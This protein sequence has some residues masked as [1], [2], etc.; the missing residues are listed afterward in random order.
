[1]TEKMG[2]VPVL[3]VPLFDQPSLRV[4]LQMPVGSS[5]AEYIAAALPAANEETLAHLRVTLVSDRGAAVIERA[6]WSRVYPHEGV[7]VVLRVIP[8]KNALRSILQ[9]VV[10]IAA[11]AIG[12]IF[13][14]PLAGALGISTGLASAVIGLGVT[15]LGGML[16]N[17]LIPPPR[18]KT[19]SDADRGSPVYAISG[20]RNEYRPGGVI[21]FP[22]GSHRYAPPYACP[23]YSEVVGDSHYIRAVFIGGYGP[24]LWDDLRIGETS[25]D[26]FQSVTK[27]IRNGWSNDNTLTFYPRQVFEENINAELTRPLPRSAGGDVISGASIETPVKRATGLDAWQISIIFSF[28]GGLVQYN[29]DGVAQTVQV[30]FRVRY[31]IAGTE[32]WTTHASFG[33]ISKKAE[34]FFRQYTF[35][36]PARGRYEIEITRLTDEHVSPKIQSRSMFAVLQTIRPE[37]PLNFDKKLALVAVRALATHQLQGSLD[38]FNAIVRCYCQDFDV[39]TGTWIQRPTSNPA[40]LYKYVLT[41]AANPRAVDTDELDWANLIEWHNFCRIKGLKYDRVIDF[42]ITLDELLREIAAAGRARPRHDGIRYGVVIDRPQEL[43][44]DHINPRNSYNFRASR[45]YSRKPHGFRVPFVDA[46][47]DYQPSERIVRWPGYNGDITLTERLEMPG[48][49][50]P[51]E[52][53]IEAR[54]RMYEAIYRPDVYTAVQDGPIRAATRGDMVIGSFDVLSRTQRAARVKAVEG[55]IVQLDDIVEMSAVETYGLRWRVFANSADTIGISVLNRVLTQPGRTDVLML[56][57]TDDRPA[58]GEIVHFGLMSSESMPLIV[59]GVESGE[60]FSSHYRLIDAS[61]IIDTLTDAEVAPPWS[62]RVGGEIDPPTVP[63]AVPVWVSIESGFSG[64]GLANGLVVAINPGTTS[65]TVTQLIRIEHRLQG[66][67][68]WNLITIAAGAGG[69]PITGYVR[70]DIVEL[71]AV[72]LAAGGLASAY[73]ATVTA[74]VGSEDGA[75]PADLDVTSITVSPLIGGAMISFETTDDSA[76]ASIQLHRAT[77][78]NF[79]DASPAGA[80]I[81]VEPSRSYSQPD[82]DTTRTNMLTN[83]DFAGSSPWAYGTGWAY[84]AGTAKHTPAASEGNLVQNLTLTAGKTYRIAYVVSGRTAGTVKPKLR[85]GTEVVGTIRSS[86]GS[87]SDS[88]VAVSGNTNFALTASTDFDGTIDNVVVFLET[89]TSLPAGVHYYWLSPLNADG[90]P[91]DAAGAF[92]VTIR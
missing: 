21:P 59:S 92:S 30:N 68:T 16:I 65:I 6:Y 19:R 41:S 11:V 1:M 85:G 38:S 14:A 27:E 56:L 22:L 2:T 36:L 9:I 7:Q 34:G 63:P 81:P 31:R 74:T 46:S 33:F 8:G 18:P 82:G 67:S 42:E 79:L 17:A 72:A 52:I 73:T 89:A 47:N 50:D 90:V 91:G 87:F 5:I 61:P 10:S 25:I 23:P 40:S 69:S 88:L 4:S 75:I 49:T 84:N 37:Y 12:A 64:T 44:V 57:D 29:D 24:V 15:V 71:R 55:S 76:T 86:N 43:A 80:P 51:N 32:A 60:D 39:A 20:W 83:G 35:Q 45:V 3:S 77:T 54:R 28:P 62:G 53:W 70:E 78:A 66:S 13:A 58:I 26:E 48:K